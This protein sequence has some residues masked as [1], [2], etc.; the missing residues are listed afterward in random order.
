MRMNGSAA[1]VRT[2]FITQWFDPEPGAIRGLPLAKWLMQHGHDVEVLTGFPNYPGGKLYPGYQ[3]RVRRREVMDGV[4]IVRVPLYPSHDTSAMRRIANYASFA[5]SA[6]TIGAASVRAADVGFVYH[7]PATVGLASL[8]LRA[9]RKLPFVY[10]IADMWPESVVESGFVRDGRLRHTVERLINSWCSTL[11][12]A[13]SAITVLSPGFKRLLIERGVPASKVHVIYNWTDEDVF[14]PVPRN[15]A[16]AAELGLANRF[17]VIYA[18]NIG[19][20]QGLETVIDAA[21]LLRDHPSIQFV[22]V[23]T[24]QDES[25][26]KDL[27]SARGIQNVRFI[28]RR[29]YWEMPEI[30]ALADVLLV[31]LRDL[32]FFAATVPSKTQVSLASGRPV[33]MAARGDAA[34]IVEEAG[35]GISCRPEDPQA[36][37]DAVVKLSKLS[38]AERDAMGARGR[39]HYLREMSLER[40]GVAM[41]ALLRRV[42]RRPIVEESA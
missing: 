39:E 7:P 40:G 20:F 10:H 32:P 24:G 26:L 31:Q 5:F 36:L 29:Q 11:Y 17:N 22:L 1:A 16:L 37:A 33:L 30:N 2:L 38:A 28:G 8:V 15:E 9:L 21:A 18:G 25:R 35:A 41:D 3:L 14:R 27:A 34:R 4:P 6:A 19:I 42:A 12:R 23:G 13:A